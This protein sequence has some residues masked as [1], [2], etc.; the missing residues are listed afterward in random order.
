M[1]TEF[2]YNQQT[3]N[4]R[5]DGYLCASQMC[6][7]NGK[8]LGDWKRL[9]ATAAYL[10]E[11]SDAMG[12]PIAELIESKNGVETW[13]HPSLAINLARWISAKFAVWCDAHIFNLMTSGKTSLDIDPLEEMKLKIEYERLK[14]QNLQSEF[15]LT[16]FRYTVVNTCPEPVQQ[17]VLGYQ[18]VE[19]IVVNKQ[20]YKENEFIRNDSTINKTKLC[21][22]YKILTKNGKPDYP[23][24]NKIL[25]TANL[26]E[27]AWYEVKDIQTNK[28]LK[29]EYLNILD[30][31]IIDDS[32]QLWIGE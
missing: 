9:K 15:A 32:R 8:L 4:Q 25:A 17:K 12:I 13:V 27:S 16:Q 24:L 11:L 28:E 19:K 31:L 2:S 21:Q 23:R 14:G 5:E 6:L 29:K 30:N 18:L 1:L 22:R 7:A 10:K 20:V 3:I 26:P